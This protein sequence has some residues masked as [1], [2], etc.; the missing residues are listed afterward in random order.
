M[1]ETICQSVKKHAG[2]IW[3]YSVSSNCEKAKSMSQKIESLLN[4]Y[5]DN[6]LL[7]ENDYIILQN[8]YNL[9]S[10]IWQAYDYFSSLTG[11]EWSDNHPDNHIVYDHK[12]ILQGH[13]VIPWRVIQLTNN[14]SANFEE[15][16][17]VN[18]VNMLKSPSVENYNIAMN[19]L[20]HVNISTNENIIYF[21]L[22]QNYISASRR[23]ILET[24]PHT[25][26]ETFDFSNW[27]YYSNNNCAHEYYYDIDEIIKEYELILKC[28]YNE[29]S[30]SQ[31]D[32]EII[33]KYFLIPHFNASTK[34]KLKLIP[35]I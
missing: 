1:S 31:S 32:M 15:N 35:T 24:D 30:I 11:P 10:E 27:V 7:D 25:K 3:A 28:R 19:I 2:T 22:I 12:I 6:F 26:F 16:K 20:A 29:R 34:F 17:F 14:P 21:L 8:E 13:K 9:A 18:I 33:A 4:N 5:I 23:R